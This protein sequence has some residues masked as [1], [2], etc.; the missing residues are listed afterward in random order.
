[1]HLIQPLLIFPFLMYHCQSRSLFACLNALFEVLHNSH[2]TH[3]VLKMF[4]C[5]ILSRLFALLHCS[6]C[7]PSCLHYL[8]LTS[9]PFSVLLVCTV[10][11]LVSPCSLGSFGFLVSRVF[12][13]ALFSTPP[14]T[15]PHFSFLHVKPFLSLCSAFFCLWSLWHF[16]VYWNGG[17]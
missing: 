17:I 1:M 12:S 5:S 7:P 14:L 9:L 13:Y 3:R 10:H 11:G 8:S 16:K 2:V 6:I 15:R 4:Y